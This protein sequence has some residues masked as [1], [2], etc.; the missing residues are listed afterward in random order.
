MPRD[1][2]RTGGDIDHESPV[3]GAAYLC[4]ACRTR[5]T[6][7]AGPTDCP[8]CREVRIKWTNYELMRDAGFLA[9]P[10]GNSL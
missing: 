6:G 2:P 7:L 3:R 10:D 1:E 4:H 5:W 8:R 9:D